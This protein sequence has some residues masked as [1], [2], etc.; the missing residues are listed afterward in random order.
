M[1]GD[2]LDVN[3]TNGKWSRLRGTILDGDPMKVNIGG[4]TRNK[5][6]QMDAEYST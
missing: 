5:K 4:M 2:L 6:P 3:S 1:L